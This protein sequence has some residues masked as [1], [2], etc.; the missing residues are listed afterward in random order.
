[1]NVL[2]SR[3]IYSRLFRR[4]AHYEK[5]KIDELR[6]L[7]E[8]GNWIFHGNCHDCAIPVKIEA[9]ITEEGEMIVEGGAIYKR[10]ENYFYKCDNCYDKDPVLRNWQECE[11]WSRVVG[12]LRPINQWN[13]G[14]KAQYAERK[15][16]RNAT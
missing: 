1:M 8:K 10:G 11:V 15:L 13:E 3:M 6:K 16:F 2:S 12:Y 9:Y 14:M 5:M 4:D 7:L